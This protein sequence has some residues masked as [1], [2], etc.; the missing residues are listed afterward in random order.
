MG[1]GVIHLRRGTFWSVPPGGRDDRRESPSR[2]PARDRRHPVG[3]PALVP[4]QVDHPCLD[5]GVAQ[6]LGHLED[7]RSYLVEAPIGAGVPKGL[8]RAAVQAEPHADSDDRGHA[9]DDV[10][11]TADRQPATLAVEDGVVFARCLR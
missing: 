7:R 8:D 2:H 5:V 3:Q 11:D 1:L 10:V 6:D 9:L 4:V